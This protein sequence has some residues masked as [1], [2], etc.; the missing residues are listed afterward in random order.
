MRGQEI[1]IFK[2]RYYVLISLFE[3]IQVPV[4]IVKMQSYR[5]QEKDTAPEYAFKGEIVNHMFKGPGMLKFKDSME[6]SGPTWKHDKQT[7]FTFPKLMP[8][9]PDNVIGTWTNGVVE[10]Q[11]KISGANSTIIAV[12]SAGILHGVSR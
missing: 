2:Q 6:L 9:K 12:A 8:E 11:V 7:C 5:C 4:N 10:G 3:S 1:T